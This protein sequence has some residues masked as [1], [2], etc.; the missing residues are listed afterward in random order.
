MYHLSSISATPETSLSDGLHT[1]EVHAVDNAGNVSSS[2]SREV[3]ISTGALAVT[4]TT[5]ESNATGVFLFP[6]ITAAFNNSLLGSTVTAENFMVTGDKT[7]VHATKPSYN[8]STRTVTFNQTGIFVT[9]ET[10]TCTVDT[11]VRN[12]SGNPL[13]GPYTWTF[14]TTTENPPATTLTLKA[15]LQGYYNPSTG[16]QVPATIEVEL[17]NGSDPG[18]A[19]PGNMVT[20][21]YISLDTTGVGTVDIYAAGDFYLVIKHKAGNTI[22]PNHLAI[23]TNDKVPFGGGTASVNI[24]EPSAGNYYT[25][26][27]VAPFPDA[28][29]TEANSTMSLRAGDIDADGQVTSSGDLP[30]WQTA[31]QSGIK[32]GETG[33]D[34]NSDLDGDGSI[35]ASGDLPYWRVNWQ[36]GAKSFVPR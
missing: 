1:W 34:P 22:G 17:R 24:S 21:E 10:I 30:F 23:I 27:S 33:F 31:W 26:Y 28:M 8:D 16:L 4:S 32:Q 2:S 12:I 29:T 6:N 5:P 19:F 15:Y 13:A 11:G 20:S 36:A 3:N 14:T 7:G 35:T 18:T 9:S 25:A